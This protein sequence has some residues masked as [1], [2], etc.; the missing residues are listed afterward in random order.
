[1]WVL[2]LFVGVGLFVSLGFGGY[3]LGGYGLGF[4]V[5][6]LIAYLVTVVCLLV[7]CSRLF[8][9]V[10]L[11]SRFCSLWVWRF[12]VCLGLWWV[13][14]L[15]RLGL[16]MCLLFGFCCF[17]FCL[18]VLFGGWVLLGLVVSVGLSGLVCVFVSGFLF[19]VCVFFGVCV[20]FVVLWF[21]LGVLF[22]LFCVG[23]GGGFCGF[24]LILCFALFLGLG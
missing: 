22:G 23:V 10:Y 8:A 4:G 7:V 19:V 11:G 5:G 20:F 21:Y 24:H 14:S 16:F 12:W 9:G 18:V 1:M 6:C 15:F 13:Y 17:W 2:G 3:D